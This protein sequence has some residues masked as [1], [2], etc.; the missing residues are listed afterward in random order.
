MIFRYIVLCPG[1]KAKIRLRLSVG[2]DNEQP[3]YFVCNRCKAATRGKQ[4]IWY[5]PQPGA[6]L[7]LEDGEQI[8]NDDNIDQVF[9]IHPD[10]PSKEKAAEMWDEGGSPFIMHHQLLGERFSEFNHRHKIFREVSDKDWFKARRWLGYYVDSHGK[11]LTRKEDEYLRKY[12]LRLLKSGNVM[13]LYI[14]YST[15]SLLPYGSIHITPT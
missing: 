2:L 15:V 1:C 14:M 7:E 6:R 11:I 10:L 12:G 4:V 8:D 13:T 3:F 9:N 5:E